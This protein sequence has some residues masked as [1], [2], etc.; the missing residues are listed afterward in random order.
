MIKIKDDQATRIAKDKA[1][2]IVVNI[3]DSDLE[4]DPEGSEDDIFCP[5]WLKPKVI[6]QTPSIVT[7]DTSYLN[8]KKQHESNPIRTNKRNLELGSLPYVQAPMA[9]QKKKIDSPIHR[10]F[11]SQPEQLNQFQKV[12]I[13]IIET[14]IDYFKSL[15]LC[16]TVYSSLLLNVA[17]YKNIL[18]SQEKLLIFQDIVLLAE[19]SKTFI[20]STID[21]LKLCN[22]FTNAQSLQKF[23]LENDNQ[24]FFNHN[25][26]QLVINSNVHKLDIGSIIHQLFKA[27]NFK[28]TI[29]VYFAKH[30]FRMK[31]LNGKLTYGGPAVSKWLKEADFLTKSK[32]KSWSLQTILIQPMQRTMK[33]PLLIKQLIDSSNSIS[34][35]VQKHELNLALIKINLIIDGCNTQESLSSFEEIDKKSK[36][37]ILDKKKRDTFYDANLEKCIP[38]ENELRLD[39]ATKESTPSNCKS[40]TPS[41]GK[42]WLPI[43]NIL[44]AP[45][46]KLPVKRGGQYLYLVTSFRDKYN[47][48]KDLQTSFEMFSCQ[49]IAFMQQQSK[50]ASLWKQFLLESDASHDGPA[51][52][53]D[54]IYSSYVDKMETQLLKTHLLVEELNTKLI[55]SITLVI[56]YCDE[57]KTQIQMHRKLR[58]SYV[59]YIKECEQNKHK[60]NIFQKTYSKAQTCINIENQ[61]K[62][63]LPQLLLYLSIFVNLLQSHSIR[64]YLSWLREQIGERSLLEFKQLRNPSLSK[65]DAKST[66]ADIIQFYHNNMQLTKL[67]LEEGHQGLDYF[68][69]F[70]AT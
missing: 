30:N 67:A 50:Y 68:R 18:T 48:I 16:R 10:S 46:E 65:E 3:S 55:S 12:L 24:N 8:F 36:Q 49:L 33:Y 42:S 40:S 57:V 7:S 54:S 63:K 31:I 44:F 28:P 37:A 20:K 58:S 29:L 27:T 45:K 62:D 70:T 60:P 59:T 17:E 5:S 21:S 47:K 6:S 25:I 52:Y 22:G 38:L 39:V 61:L 13:E 34:S 9:S 23:E 66:H 19:I 2:K 43:R 1:R 11:F 56:T 4:S 32:T 26:R 14:E 53:I 69:H 41:K 15:N 35:D 64:L 51:H